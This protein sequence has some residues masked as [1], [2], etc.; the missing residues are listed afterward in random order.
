MQAKILYNML[1]S[2]TNAGKNIYTSLFNYTLKELS[3]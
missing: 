1:S 2:I 3:S